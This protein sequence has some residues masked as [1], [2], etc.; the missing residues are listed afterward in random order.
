MKPCL[1][2]DNHI[3]NILDKPGIDIPKIIQRIIDATS[4]IKVIKV[5][6]HLNGRLIPHDEKIKDLDCFDK[7]PLVGAG[8]GSPEMARATAC[9][10]NAPHPRRLQVEPN[11]VKAFAANFNPVNKLLD[12]VI[13]NTLEEV[14]AENV[15]ATGHI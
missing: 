8:K 9:D 10:V 7:I 13:S 6:I 4:Q 2:A 14:R 11:W 3:A 12:A 15:K 5:Y 1:S